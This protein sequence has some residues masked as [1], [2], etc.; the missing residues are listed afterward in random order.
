MLYSLQLIDMG[1]ME[2]LC[3]RLE[4]TI[5][6]VENRK[7]NYYA[8]S[9]INII[10]S[11]RNLLLEWSGCFIWWKGALIMEGTGNFISMMDYILDTHRKR[12]ITGGILLS[13]SL[14]FGG[15]ALTVM[16]IKT[17]GDNNEQ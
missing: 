14:L 5:F 7:E 4:T 10:S 6:Q 1:I 11:C 8:C 12:H 17:E 2:H 13:A 15:L 9:G 16:T 3:F